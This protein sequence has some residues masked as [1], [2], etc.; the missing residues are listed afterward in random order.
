MTQAALLADGIAALG[1]AAQAGADAQAKLLAYLALLD[2]WNRTH[3][4]TAIREPERMVT[5]H[6][7]D[8]LAVLPHLPPQAGLRL[9]DIGSGGGLPGIPLAIVRQDWQLVLLDGNFKKAAFL[10]QAAIELPL[11]NVEVVAARAEDYAPGVAFDI[12]ISRA[13]SDLAIFA[14]VARNLLAPGGRLVAMKGVYPHEELAQLPAGVG[15]T[16]TPA[17]HVPG[18]DGARHLVIMERA[19]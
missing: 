9:I 11:P 3:N 16:A 14:G 2:K 19:A 6:L 17:L 12:A 18:L 13:F 4:L 7:L 8:S 10:R 15:V 5:H 1:L